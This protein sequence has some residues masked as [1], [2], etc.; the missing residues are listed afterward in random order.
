M[1]RYEIQGELVAALGRTEFH[2]HLS[3]KVEAC[4]KSFRGRRHNVSGCGATWARAGDS[5]SLA[6]LC[7]HCAHRRAMVQAARV[8][9]LMIGRE[10]RLRYAVLS[11]KNSDNL[12]EGIASLWNAWTRLRRSVQWKR[13]VKGAIVVLE[14][15]YNRESRTWHPHLNV[16]MEGEY[17][18]FELL[19]QLWIW[20]TNGNGRGS[21]IQAA[22]E[23]KSAFELVKYTLKVAER[24][25]D[26]NGAPSLRL[27]LDRPEAIDEFLSATY[28]I[29]LI[30]TYGTFF[31]KLADDEENTEQCPDCGGSD[32]IEDL[33]PLA[34]HQ[35]MFDFEKDVFRIRGADKLRALHEHPED[36]CSLH[37]R[38][39]KGL[40][41]GDETLSE[42]CKRR[43]REALAA[44]FKWKDQNKFKHSLKDKNEHIAQAIQTRKKA[45]AYER[46]V[47]VRLRAA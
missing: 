6:R 2:R 3:S 37:M 32:G 22:N 23:K 18:P 20:A 17:F 15:T 13:K 34:S 12:E 46:S 27:I 35:L 38:Y 26:E 41:Y 36:G 31:G 45:A 42:T 1:D 33:G 10:D 14:V 43:E 21:H 5:C 7:P 24:T 4:H 25:K 19:N 30:R 44:R 47:S 39:L 40:D 8:Q 16:L 29:R 11:E 28:S 9:K